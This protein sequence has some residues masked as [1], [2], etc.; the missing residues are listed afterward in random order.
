MKIILFISLFTVLTIGCKKD[1]SAVPATAD[2]TTHPQ[3]PQKPM[4]LDMLPPH[5]RAGIEAIDQSKLRT[6]ES[7]AKVYVNLP[8]SAMPVPIPPP[9]RP[10]KDPKYKEGT[11]STAVYTF[12]AANGHSGEMFLVRTIKGNDTVWIP[13]HIL[14]R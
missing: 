6:H 14:P 7:A 11:D 2:T 13:M 12:T 10:F 9:L 1:E 5:M 8:D 4:S 3:E